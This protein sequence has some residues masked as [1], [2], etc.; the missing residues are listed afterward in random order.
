MGCCQHNG[1]FSGP[2]YNMAAAKVFQ[3]GCQFETL[4]STI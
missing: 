1:P 2:A 4:Q 3:T